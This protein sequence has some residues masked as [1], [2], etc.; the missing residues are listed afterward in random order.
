MKLK[1]MKLQNIRP[2]NDETVGR[3]R[4]HLANAADDTKKRE[5]AIVWGGYVAALIEW[6]LISINEYD[7]I[8]T[9]L[10]PIIGDEC[11]PTKEVFL[12]FDGD[13]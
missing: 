6:Q 13:G 3:V 8:R 2:D 10:N 12:G 1:I 9:L 7:L 4:K 5:I 11:D